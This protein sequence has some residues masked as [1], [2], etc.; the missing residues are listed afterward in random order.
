MSAFWVDV[1]LREIDSRWIAS[2]GPSLGLGKGH[3]FEDFT[4]SL[5]LENRGARQ[6][7]WATF[8]QF[9]VKR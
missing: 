6:S 9:A 5:D 4:K 1:R 3:P 2:D 7:R 8:T